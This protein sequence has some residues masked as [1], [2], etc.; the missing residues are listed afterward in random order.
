MKRILV[1]TLKITMINIKIAQ[2]FLFQNNPL[3]LAV[4]CILRVVFRVQ[5]SDAFMYYLQ[6]FSWMLLVPIKKE[7]LIINKNNILGS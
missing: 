4:V 6:L 5:F 1:C 7:K 2:F 3:T